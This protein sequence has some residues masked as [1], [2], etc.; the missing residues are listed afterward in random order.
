MSSSWKRQAS[1][2]LF[3]AAA[4][5]AAFFGFPRAAQA[6]GCP[7][8]AV[9]DHGGSHWCYSHSGHG[10]VH[11]WKPPGYA[12]DTAVLIVYIHGFDTGKNGP[13]TCNGKRPYVDCIWDASDH[14]I[15]GQFASS[16][17]NALFVAVSGQTVPGDARTWG[18]LGALITSIEQR[19]KIAVPKDVTVLGHSAGMQ[20]TL[21]L[22]DDERLKHVTSVDWVANGIDEKLISWYGKGAG[23][24]LTLLGGSGTQ[25]ALMDA[26]AKTLACT[27]AKDPKNLSSDEL[28]VRCVQM[29]T[30]VGH[31]RVVLDKVYMPQAMMRSTTVAAAGDAA[32][33]SGATGGGT[34]AGRPLQDA[35]IDAPLLEIPV[36]GLELSGAIREN[37]GITIPWLAQYVGGVYTFLLSIVGMVAAV[38]MVVGG[39][40][41]L[42]SGGDTTKVAAGRKRIVNALSGLILALSS[43]VILFVIN[44]NLVSFDGLKIAGVSTEL[45][46]IAEDH[47][48][49]GDL[50][51]ASSGGSLPPIQVSSVGFADHAEPL[52]TNSS[53]PPCSEWCRNLGHSSTWP[54]TTKGF[55]PIEQTVVIE[56]YM[57]S[58]A[59]PGKSPD[60]IL[61]DAGTGDRAHPT[62][63]DALYAAAKQAVLDYPDHEYKIGISECWRSVIKQIN[64]ACA[65][66]AGAFTGVR[67]VV[68][69]G[70]AYPGGSNHGVGYACDLRLYDGGRNML[71]LEGKVVNGK[72]DGATKAQ[73]YSV[74]K[75]DSKR[76]DD[77]MFKVGWVRYAAEVWHYEYGSPSDN[78]CGPNAAHG[79]PKECVFPPKKFC[80]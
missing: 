28:A 41:Y 35:A 61:V 16:G 65:G 74:K 30:S 38:M 51:E 73:C 53:K 58:D 9:A 19:G 17:V 78:R 11:I 18:S 72:R 77:I 21:N 64:N 66:A 1:S 36:P 24:K 25:N 68:P 48:P 54:T 26:M 37:G 79:G 22:L 23:R 20:T 44:P 52:C 57:L 49:S 2:L 31:M 56:D 60:R 27:K 32:A 10:N 39:F 34:V 46:G 42:T 40:Q 12:A 47:D 70:V 76:F 5:S 45:Y 14:D 55:M 13:D 69:A 67:S 33:P 4:A 43:Y 15:V 59:F 71:P 3:L 63:R 29:R 8:S 75:E 6:S 80:G 62:V 7:S 50:V